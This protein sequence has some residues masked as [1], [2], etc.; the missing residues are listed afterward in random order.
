MNAGQESLS[1]ET[2]VEMLQDPNPLVRVRAGF[3]L[4]AI[5]DAALPA[6]PILIE[7]LTSGGVQDRKLAATTLGEIGPEAIEAV[8]ALL[9]AA[10]DED[11]SVSDLAGWALERIDLVDEDI[12]EAA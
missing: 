12:E 10:S 3:A 2:L 6:V 7:M 11:D 4:A 5:K 8:P 9:E 1:V